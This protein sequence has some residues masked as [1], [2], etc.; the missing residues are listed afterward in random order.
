MTKADNAENSTSIGSE[1]IRRFAKEEGLQLKE[2]VLAGEWRMFELTD[3]TGTTIWY[4]LFDDSCTVTKSLRVGPENVE[5]VKEALARLGRQHRITCT[6]RV[7]NPVGIRVGDDPDLARDL[8]REEG[9][10]EAKAKL[11]RDGLPRALELSVD[12][13]RAELSDVKQTYLSLAGFEKLTYLSRQERQKTWRIS[14]NGVGVALI[15]TSIFGIIAAEFSPVFWGQ[16]LGLLYGVFGP[17]IFFALLAPGVVGVA[18]LIVLA[19]MHAWTG[20]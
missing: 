1:G 13:E 7:L 3:G 12:F 11:A 19:I 4:N 8:A 17:N 20:R 18:L 16:P 6:V 9:T 5:Q 15:M 10:S 14:G 2:E